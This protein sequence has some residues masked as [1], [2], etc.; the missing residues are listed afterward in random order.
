M[1]EYEKLRRCESDSIV[2]QR[3]AFVFVNC[4]ACNSSNYKFKFSKD[5]F[6]FVVCSNCETLFVNPRPT[7]EMLVSFYEKSFCL[8]YW[9]DYIYPASE[10]VRRKNIFAPR[11]LRVVDLCKKY[12]LKKNVIVDVGAG[13][14]TFLEEINK[15]GY[16]ESSLAI[17]P[18]QSLFNTCIKKG[19]DAINEPVENVDLKNANVVTSFELIEHLFDPSKFLIACHRLLT[20]GGLLIV[21]TPNI[22]GFDLFLLGEKSKNVTAPNHINYF[23]IKS[24]SILLEKVGFEIV[25]NLTPGQI[26]LDIVR[27]AILRGDVTFQEN[28]FLNALLS[29]DD[30][31]IRDNFQKFLI[32]NKLSSHLWIVARKI[33]S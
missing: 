33:C 8:K 16:F 3:D 12:N 7:F 31:I 13:Y 25:E 15:I 14:G 4:P 20:D 2:Q 23:N 10:E 21:T 22:K 18:S 6:E 32:E 1:Q 29:G 30:S 9:N 17:E 27:N 26:D 19:I 24:L 5:K 28:C 11:A